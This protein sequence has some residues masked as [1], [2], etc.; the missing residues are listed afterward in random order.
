MIDLIFTAAVW[1]FLQAPPE[2]VTIQPG[3]F[4]MGCSEGDSLC[5]AD[6]N[7][8][9]DVRITKAFQLSTHEVTQAEWQAL[10]QTNPSRFKGENLP[11]ENISFDEVQEYLGK[12]NARNDGYRYR[13][14]TEAEW[15]YAARAGTKGANSGPLDEIAWYM[16]NSNGQSHPVKQKKPNAFGLYD[17]EGNVYEWTQDWFFDYEEDPLTDPKGPASGFERVP[18]GGSWN[19]TPKGVRTSNRNALEPD[20]GDFNVGFRV[21]REAVQ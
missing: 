17:M 18:R 10:M 5:D 4:R 8:P 6:E 11:V 16:N 21:A 2:F 20:A 12:L 1:T 15:E 7:P 3:S 14:P 13:L 19:S 9:H